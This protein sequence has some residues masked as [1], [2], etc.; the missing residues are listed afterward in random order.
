MECTLSATSNLLE[1]KPERKHVLLGKR[2]LSYLHWECTNPKRPPLVCVHGLTRNAHDFDAIGAYL[3]TEQTIY[4]IDMAGRGQSN[5]LPAKEVYSYE[6]YAQDILAFLSALEIKQID[7]LGTS[8]GGI[9]GMVLGS[10]H[11]EIFRK[12]IINDISAFIPLSAMH[13][14]NDYVGRQMLHPNKKTAMEYVKIF[15]GAF[16]LKEEWQWEHLFAHSFRLLED[17]QYELTY[18]P[19]IMNTIRDDK[20]ELTLTGDVDLWP[21]WENML[22]PTLL[23]RGEKSD[24]LNASMQQEMLQRQSNAETITFSGCGHAPALMD[25]EQIQA[26]ANWL[27]NS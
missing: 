2:K 13:R 1:P 10:S 15:Y 24:F 26:V 11:P 3:S 22:N 14:L 18:D 8:M 5:W 20:G 21:F 6:L 4:S 19:E 25:S 17:G 16:G 12:M 27:N 9:L 7:W 23:L